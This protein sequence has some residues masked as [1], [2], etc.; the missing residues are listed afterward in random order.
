[1]PDA[2]AIARP[3]AIVLAGQRR[4]AVNP[5]AA[6]AGV[7]HKCLAPIAGRP[8]IAHV[9]AT[10]TAVP[11]LAEIRVSVESEAEAELR[12]V[13]APFAAAGVPITLVPSA[14]RLSDSLVAASGQDA[15]PFLVTT[16]DNVLLTPEAVAQVRAALDG[17]D[18]VAA[19]ARKA[20]VLA[21]H[22]EGQRNFYRFRDDDYANCNI[23]ALGNRKAIDAGAEVFRG[24]GQFM[25]SVWRMISA[26]GLHNIVLLRL[27]AFSREA[28]MRRLSRRLGL[29]VRAIE[30][31]DGALAVD[32][33]NERTYRVCEE[34][35][36][37][38]AQGG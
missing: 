11:A 12:Q 23:Y 38:R 32:V 25:K 10:L 22:P 21:A 35:L 26:F 37:R 36:A 33:D 14:A 3:I 28:A 7:S 2:P 20:S 19:M 8:L 31:T 30:F 13:I 9:L 24:G 15:G 17:A 18:A 34:I 6:R 27:G 1:M 5:L 4:G 16:A 29:V